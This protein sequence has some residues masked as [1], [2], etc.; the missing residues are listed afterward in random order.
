MACEM[1]PD[2]GTRDYNRI[3][4]YLMVL[5]EEHGALVSRSHYTLINLVAMF[6]EVMINDALDAYFEEFKRRQA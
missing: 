5:E 3:E 1:Y 6:G 4:P 2:L